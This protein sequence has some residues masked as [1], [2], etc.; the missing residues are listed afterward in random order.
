[1]I[2]DWVKIM[3]AENNGGY[4][5]DWLVGNIKTGEIAWLELGTYNH[6][7]DR[8]FDGAFV[9][10]NMAASEQVRAETKFNYDDKSGSCT[11]RG[12][13]WTQLIEANRTLIDVEM[14]KRFLADHHDA[15][16]GKD[17]P[18]RNTLCGHLEL[19]D[20]G[21]PE[22]E[23]GP[24]YPSGAYDGKVTD[25][26]LAS[27]GKFWAHWGKPCDTDFNASS[28]LSLHQEYSWQQPHL[29]D[30]KAYPW[31]LFKAASKREIS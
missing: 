20:R 17:S 18:N 3:V 8:T 28:F 4:A 23:R 15:F 13:R 10:S 31:T 16:S 14:A 30:V 6:A 1:M 29:R 12:Q 24:Y 21:A 25:S 9:G 26:D 19:D 2:D 27:K 22:W 11:A 5:N 7:L